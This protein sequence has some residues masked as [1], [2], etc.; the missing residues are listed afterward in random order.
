MD[1]C[2]IHFTDKNEIAK[3]NSR[4]DQSNPKD[5]YLTSWCIE[6]DS[7]MEAK[8]ARKVDHATRSTLLNG[9]IS[10]YIVYGHS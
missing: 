5:G 9:S 7:T 4:A 3:H 6:N 2:S 10:I 8:F 1:N